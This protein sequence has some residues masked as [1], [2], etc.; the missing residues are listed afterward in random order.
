MKSSRGG[1]PD[2]RPAKRAKKSPM[3]GAAQSSEAG[4]GSGLPS[5][6]ASEDQLE[7]SDC[8]YGLVGTTAMVP[9]RWWGNGVEKDMHAHVFEAT[10][11]RYDPCFQFKKGVHQAWILD[12]EEDEDV[13]PCSYYDLCHFL[14]PSDRPS[15]YVP[16]DDEDAARD[17][18]VDVDGGSDDETLKGVRKRKPA[19]KGSAGG[20]SSTVDKKAQKSWSEG[21][22][23][24]YTYSAPTTSLPS[25][26]AAIRRSIERH[27]GVWKE[28]YEVEGGYRKGYVPGHEL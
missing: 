21:P 7:P 26:E 12:V 20:S 10:I 9:G 23:G 5:E 3:H 15:D 28:K 1:N 17:E 19:T 27:A 2:K 25:A 11:V 22:L 6:I 18:V 8:P 24:H 14:D 16:S 4:S 13:Y